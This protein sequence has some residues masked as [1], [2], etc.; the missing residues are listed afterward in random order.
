MRRKMNEEL[1]RKD[2][3]YDPNSKN[4][5]LISMSAHPTLTQNPYIS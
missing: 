3:R 1:G 5:G 4:Q 2:E